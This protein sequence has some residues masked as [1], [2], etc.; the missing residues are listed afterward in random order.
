MGWIEKS[1][2]IFNNKNLFL[3]KIIEIKWL[4]DFVLK[5]ISSE[6]WKIDETRRDFLKLLL[7]TPLTPVI[8]SANVNSEDIEKIVK[9][10]IKWPNAQKQAISWIRNYKNLSPDLKIALD[11]LIKIFSNLDFQIVWG[12]WIKES[13]FDRNAKSNKNATWIFQLMPRTYNNLVKFYNSNN[14]YKWP[15]EKFFSDLKLNKEFNEIFKKFP[16]EAIAIAY[17]SFLLK[18]NNWSKMKALWEYNSWKSKFDEWWKETIN[19][20][21]WDASVLKYWNVFE[22][23]KI[24]RLI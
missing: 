22:K 20:V 13:K 17:I 14:K 18:K 15:E 2:E 23:L 11:K 8:L 7:L 16:H 4:F 24:E 19:Y 9:E 12:M 10:N 5:W 3:K 21:L 6:K 1:V